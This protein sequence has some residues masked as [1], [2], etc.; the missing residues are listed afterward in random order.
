MGNTSSGTAAS[1]ASRTKR[2]FTITRSSLMARSGC[3]NPDGTGKRQLTD[4]H[5]EDAMPCF[6]PES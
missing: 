3:M 2:P 5:W 6:V 4:N 1:M